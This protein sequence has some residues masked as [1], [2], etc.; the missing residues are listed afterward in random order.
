MAPTFDHKR[1]LVL[2]TSSRLKAAVLVD[3]M[4][5]EIALAEAATTYLEVLLPVTLPPT[6]PITAVPLRIASRFGVLRDVARE[7]LASSQVPGAVAV[8]RC[9]SVQA[10]LSAIEPVDRLVLVGGAGWGVRRAARGAGSDV[11]VVSQRSRRLATRGIPSRP[12][13]GQGAQ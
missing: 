9:R 1:V 5:E 7:V 13:I 2:A 11:V 8:V 4:L 3:V 6:L 10:L 12:A